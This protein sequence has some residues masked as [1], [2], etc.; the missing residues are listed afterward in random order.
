MNARTNISNIICHTA[1]KHS[2][3]Q[4][5]NC[6]F[7]NSAKLRLTPTSDCA[8][9]PPSRTTIPTQALPTQFAT[10]RH[11]SSQKMHIFRIDPK[12]VQLQLPTAPATSKP[13]N[14]PIKTLPT[15]FATPR[16][17]TPPLD[18]ETPIFKSNKKLVRPFLHQ[19]SPTS[20][21]KNHSNST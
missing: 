4:T 11:H 1:P 14:V 16:R 15:Q 18:Q 6:R 9:R 5:P 20:K 13:T 17:F 7:S 21:S 3:N 19:R 10:L 2:A 12:F 8:Q